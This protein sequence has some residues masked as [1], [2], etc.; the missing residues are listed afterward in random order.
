[1]SDYIP[2]FYEDVNTNPCANPD[3]GSAN[4]CWYQGLQGPVSV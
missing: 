4:L 1:M 3:S 2:L